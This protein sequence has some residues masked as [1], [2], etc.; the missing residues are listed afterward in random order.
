MLIIYFT[1]GNTLTFSLSLSLSLTNFYSASFNCLTRWFIV[2]IIRCPTG[3]YNRSDGCIVSD[4]GSLMVGK[5][6][7]TSSLEYW[8]Q[9]MTKKMVRGMLDDWLHDDH[10]SEGLLPL[11][12]SQILSPTF[13]FIFSH[14]PSHSLSLIHHHRHHHP[15][16]L[17]HC[18]HQATYN[19][20]ELFLDWKHQE[21]INFQLPPLNES[22]EMSCECLELSFLAVLCNNNDKSEIRINPS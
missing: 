2:T 14:S 11:S 15:R 8:N 20:T 18:H 4:T 16:T 13:T 17:V 5:I 6:Q 10:H 21:W 1:L 19:H 22:L 7:A 12:L 3:Q 9:K